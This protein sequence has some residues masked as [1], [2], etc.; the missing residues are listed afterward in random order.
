VRELEVIREYY[1]NT[2]RELY[3]RG[4]NDDDLHWLMFYTLR[5]T[6]KQK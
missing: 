1:E 5:V 2:L 3:E 4:G 6:L